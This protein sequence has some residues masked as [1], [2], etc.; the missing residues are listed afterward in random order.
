MSITSNPTFIHRRLAGV[1]LLLAA[2]LAF[3]AQGANRKDELQSRP[4]VPSAKAAS[5][6][7]TDVS[8]S[9]NH[10]AVVGERGHILI[11]TDDGAT[12]RQATVPV[13]VLLTGVFFANEQVGWAVGHEGVILGTRDGGATWEVQYANP[14]KEFTDD[15]QANFTDEQ[16]NAMP[17][18]GAPLMDIWFRNENEGFAVGAYGMMLHTA[19]GGRNWDDWSSRLN[20]QDNWHLNAIGSVDGNTIYVAGEKGV[21]FR[22][23][24]AGQ[25]WGPLQGPY[26]GSF[27]GMLVG[28]APEQI[29]VFG[30]Q[31]NLFRSG[32]QGN[33]WEQIKSTTENSI[34]GG[35]RL[36]DK[37]IVL[38]GNSGVILTS[39]DGG[40]IYTL[41]ITKDRQTILGIA[42][43]ASG[44]LLMVGQGGVKLA[45][46][47]GN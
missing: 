6:L 14:Y 18:L 20:N 24:D 29:L 16:F 15:E 32:D 36:S 11:S 26:E 38:V 19:D 5:A 13:Q 25:N 41:Q 33:S 47:A 37:D 30:L 43:T 7:L 45:A 46:T 21:L 28:L 31:G 17:R 12:W 3:P 9:G 39:K 42:K 40:L 10:I 22:S 4:A 34:M 2:L 1:A 35:V 44:K 27:F 8:V 23:Q